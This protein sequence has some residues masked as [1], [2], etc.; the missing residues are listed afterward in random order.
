MA[1]SESIDTVRASVMAKIAAWKA[2]LDSYDAAVSRSAR[3]RARQPRPPLRA[4]GA[5]QQTHAYRLGVLRNGVATARRA[6]DMSN[7]SAIR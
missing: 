1:R 4:V 3:R 5:R 7:L 2:V 6:L